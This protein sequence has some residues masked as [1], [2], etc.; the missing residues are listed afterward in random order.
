MEAAMKEV[1][2]VVEEEFRTQVKT[3]SA[4]ETHGVV[5]DWRPEM[6][7]VWAS[8]QGT[9][10][11]RDELA[12]VFKLKKSQ[13]RVITEYMGGGF[14]AKFGA[15]DFGV[16]AAHLSKASGAPVKMMLPR[17]QEHLSVGHRRSSVQQLKIGAKK[18]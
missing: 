1:E 6:L 3:H 17:K 9:N 5:A 11:V 18:E 2:V 13:V 7:T 15:G 14:G 4:L 12:N 16:M 10:S 8:T